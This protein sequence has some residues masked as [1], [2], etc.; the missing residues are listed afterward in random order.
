VGGSP[1]HGSAWGWV[2]LE[3][4]SNPSRSVILWFQLPVADISAT[5]GFPVEEV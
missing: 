1:A 5:Q 3:V 4:S 2:G